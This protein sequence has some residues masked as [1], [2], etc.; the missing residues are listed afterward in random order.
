MILISFFINSNLQVSLGQIFLVFSQFKQLKNINVDEVSP[1]VFVVSIE[2]SNIMEIE[3]NCNDISAKHN[4]TLTWVDGHCS[5]LDVV[6]SHVDEPK[7]Q[8][9]TAKIQFEIDACD[10]S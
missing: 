6:S 9:Q 10:V 1:K 3:S 7:P 4:Y 2:S 8:L 5:S